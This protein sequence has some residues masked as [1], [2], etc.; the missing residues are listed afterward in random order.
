MNDVS[1]FIGLDLNSILPKPVAPYDVIGKVTEKAAE[2]TGLDVGIPVVC[3]SADS[4]MGNLE[5]GITGAGEAADVSGTAALLFFATGKKPENSHGLLVTPQCFP[6]ENAPYILEGNVNSMG[7]AM[8]WFVGVFGKTIMEKTKSND[9]LFASTGILAETAPAGSGNLLFFPHLTGER[10]PVWN[11]D[12]TGMFIGIN[13][14]TDIQH[15]SR[16]L[17]EGT[18][19]MVRN[20]T[21]IARSAGAEADK[22]YASGGCANSDIWLKI[23]ASVLKAPLHV[24]LGNGGAPQGNAVVAGFGVG[25]FNDFEAAVKRFH[26]ITKVVEPVNEWIPIYDEMYC[27]FLQMRQHLAADLHD[28]RKKDNARIR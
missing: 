7:A 12:L 11:P 22:F 5:T 19:F 1:D 14:N 18:S 20:V 4:L 6:L 24:S 26:K 8:K 16:A 3:G 27:Y 2:I 10:A 28:F 15:F 9:N 13:P 21:E 23:K 25:L 17:M